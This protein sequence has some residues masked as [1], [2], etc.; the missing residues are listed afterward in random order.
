MVQHGGIGQFLPPAYF[1]EP[2][3]TGQLLR[4]F[5]I[6]KHLH[7]LN[8]LNV[9][10]NNF[11]AYNFM[12]CFKFYFSGNSFFVVICNLLVPTRLEVK[13]KRYFGIGC[14]RE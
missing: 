9:K 2:H 5:K 12:L 4:E 6:L 10:S 14:C 13:R 3:E 7:T 1:P 8:F 11:R